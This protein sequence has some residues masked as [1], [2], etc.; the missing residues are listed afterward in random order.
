MK[1]RTVGILAALGM[2]LTTLTVWSVTPPGSKTDVSA[3]GDWLDQA[4][5]PGDT[6]AGTFSGAS[7]TAGT[8][9]A[10]EGRLGHSRLLSTDQSETLVFLDVKA[11][12]ASTATTAANA[13]L[14]IVVDRSGS[15]K[16][17]RLQNALEAARGMIRRLRDGD[18]VSVVTYNTA[19]EVVMPPTTIDGFTRDRALA[20]LDRVTAQGDTCISCGIET[21]MELL[22][23]RTGMVDRMLLLSD[24]E[25]TAGVKDVEGFRRIA[26][27]CRRMGAAISAI[28]VDVDYNERVMSVLAVESNG[29]HHFVNHP[30]DLSRAFDSELASLVKSIASDTEVSLELAPGVELV[31]VFDRSFRREGSRVIVPLGTFAAGENKTLLAKVRVARGADGERAIA[32]VRL[33]YDDLSRGGRGALDGKLAALLVSNPSEV[34]PLDPIVQN[35]MERAETASVLREANQLFT[36]GRAREAQAKLAERKQA[37]FKRKQRSIAAAPPAKAATLKDDFDRQELALGEAESGFSAPASAP[38]VAAGAAPAE[39]APPRRAKVQVKENAER[40]DAFGF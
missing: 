31:E 40:A 20:S 29:R 27:R 32:N 10:V 24:G 2:S 16:G 39:A 17:K 33:A 1:V 37:L 22:G 7:F 30:D 21:A 18:V 12:G 25:A 19:S 3:E 23:R 9:L 14:S 38:P 5:D 13:N 4:P 26:E 11:D 35:R 36:S 8:T 28:G 15:M 6:L 34:S